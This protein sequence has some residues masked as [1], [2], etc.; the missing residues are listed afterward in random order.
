MNQAFQINLFWNL[1]FKIKLTY[2]LVGVSVKYNTL[3]KSSL[4][5]IALLATTLTGVNAAERPTI[6]SD[7]DIAYVK[8]LISSEVNAKQEADNSFSF[9]GY[10]RTGTNTVIGG[11]AKNGGSC[12]SLNYPKNDGIY[13]RLGNECRDYGELKFT[14]KQQLS[15]VNFKA[16]YMIDVA[17]DSRSPTATESWSKRTRELY[18]ETD[19]LL[20]NG[21]LWM[22]RRYYRSIG[23]GDVHMLDYFYVQSSGNG[24][25]VSDIAINDSDKL[26]IAVLAYGGE[27]DI[28]GENGTADSNYQ[29]IMADIRYE[30][31]V[32]DA[33]E[34]VFTLQNLFVNDAINAAGLADGRTYTVQ[35]QKKFGIVDQKTA[36]QVGTGAMAR[37]PGS[38]G[39]DGGS[40]DYAANSSSK[41]LR[42]FNTGL[43]DISEKF[44]INYMAM[45][46]KSSDYHTLKSVGVRPHYS[47]S[48]HWSVLGE[49]GYNA[50]QTKTNGIENDEQKLMKYA[51]ALQATADSTDFWSRPSLRFY[52]SNFDW[53]NAAGQESGLNVAGKEGA[54][55]ALVA[56]AQVEVWF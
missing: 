52:L 7:E 40:F 36:I 39:T 22:G 46:E 49:V 55:S 16:V 14:K 35:W 13:Y 47:I 2:L 17:G 37:N 48:P 5:L 18:V 33:G 24:V 44:K 10:F 15:G 38:A 51:L 29:N 54:E 53:N 12:Y 30:M 21:N 4:S 27:G 20:D 1:M 42:I 56:G 25:G 31:D 34:V 19:N 43:I 41:G 32:G 3:L 6:L 50:Y 26:H 9:G 23:V 28:T 8:E 45:Y 11:G